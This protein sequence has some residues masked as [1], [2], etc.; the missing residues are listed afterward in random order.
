MKTIDPYAKRKGFYKMRF[1][2]ETLYGSYEKLL[3]ANEETTIERNDSSDNF[4]QKNLLI[5]EN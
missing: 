2:G 5:P 1:I 4:F 3:C